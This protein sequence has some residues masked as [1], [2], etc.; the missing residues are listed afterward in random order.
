MK[1]KRF[2]LLSVVLAAALLCGAFISAFAAGFND[3][4]EE[5]WYAEAVAYV[6][7]QGLM[8]GNSATEFAPEESLTRAMLVTVLYRLE[9]EP[10][11][12]GDDGFSDTAGGQWY[13]NAVLWAARQGVV[14]GY[15][16][17][18][19]GPDDS[20]TQEQLRLIMSR[21][22]DETVTRNIPGFTAGAE[23]ATR[24]QVAAVLLNLSKLPPA[25]PQDGSN[26]AEQE[27]EAMKLHIQIGDKLLTAALAQNSSAEA[28]RD[29]LADG[30][31]TVAMND[32][33]GMEKVGTLPQSLPR[34]DEQIDT[35]AGDLILYQ[36][37]SFVIYYGTNS[38]ELTRLGKIDNVTAQEL[39]DILGSGSV[40]AV[41]SLPAKQMN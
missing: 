9:S 2:M 7:E 1:N 6:Q 34:N 17:G 32:Y 30:S 20:I 19:F 40:T 29:L 12:S 41:L 33:A 24:A 16:N 5:A 11:V 37:N 39:K 25:Q 15:G 28:L 35:E 10:E 23:P 18:M 38:W 13:S 31:V 21:Y 8:K 36:G 22:A 4:P 14:N 27:G 3:V 26:A